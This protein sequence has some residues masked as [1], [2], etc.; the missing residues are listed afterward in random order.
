[1]SSVYLNSASGLTSVSWTCSV[2]NG[3]ASVVSI[4]L[5]ENSTAAALLGG[6]V[7]TSVSQEG[8]KRL[9]GTWLAH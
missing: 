7:R 1:M 6:G 9:L 8:L 4:S 3:R 2:L 5:G